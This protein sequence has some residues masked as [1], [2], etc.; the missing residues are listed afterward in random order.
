MVYESRLLA[1]SLTL[2][3]ADM[4]SSTVKCMLL[5]EQDPNLDQ[6]LKEGLADARAKAGKQIG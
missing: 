2:D 3:F 6:E 4:G 1:F 5:T